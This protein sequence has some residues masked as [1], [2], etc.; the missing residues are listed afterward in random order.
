MEYLSYRA[1]GGVQVDEVDRRPRENAVVK[2]TDGTFERRV[3]DA[4]RVGGEVGSGD[5]GEV[6]GFS[7]TVGVSL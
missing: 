6:V 2:T 4:T 1:G 3:V 5:Y 7:Y